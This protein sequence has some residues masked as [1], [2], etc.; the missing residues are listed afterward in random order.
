M[1]PISAV[2]LSLAL[3][4]G[5]TVGKEVVSAV[6]KDAYAALRWL[7][8]HAKELGVDRKRIA[9]MGESAGGGIG[10]R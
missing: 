8:E 10:R 2:A 7:D 9:V 3:G 1:E 4:A 6:V 5:A